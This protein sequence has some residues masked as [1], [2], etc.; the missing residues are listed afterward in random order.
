[1]ALG[2]NQTP[3]PFLPGCQYGQPGLDWA[4]G[5]QAGWEKGFEGC[6]VLQGQPLE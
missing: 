6:L 3:P 2:E 5:Q 1:M 4:K